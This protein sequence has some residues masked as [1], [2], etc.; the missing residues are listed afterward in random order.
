MTTEKTYTKAELFAIMD[1]I[2]EDT[3]GT[4]KDE[5]YATDYTFTNYGLSVL[6][7]VLNEIEETNGGT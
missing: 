5:W 3:D 4:S 7:E 2:L 6:K 1:K